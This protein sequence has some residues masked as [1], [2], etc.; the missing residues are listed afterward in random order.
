M[1]RTNI[2]IRKEY[3]KI[4]F[5]FDE[6]KLVDKEIQNLLLQ[7]KEEEIGKAKYEKRNSILSV[8][9]SKSKISQF[10]GSF[11]K[12]QLLNEFGEE[13]SIV[14]KINLDKNKKNLTTKACSLN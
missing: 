2:F 11:N 8:M 10:N 9:Q 7:N 3:E 6:N 14:G 5:C 12:Q 4:D 13:G 1:R